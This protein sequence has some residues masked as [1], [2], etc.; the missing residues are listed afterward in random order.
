MLSSPRLLI[1][2]S[3][4]LV[5]AAFFLPWV[6][7]LPGKR[8]RIERPGRADS[9]PLLNPKMRGYLKAFSTGVK[10][11][12]LTVRS[13]A[14]LS[15]YAIPQAANSEASKAAVQLAE[16]FQGK[17][18]KK[19]V[20]RSVGWK[21]YAVYLVPGLHLFLGALLLRFGRLRWAAAI[22]GLIGLVVPPIAYWQI[23]KALAQS[24]GLATIE[25]GLWLSLLAYWVLAAA[26][27]SFTKPPQGLY[28]HM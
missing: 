23:T 22:V 19:A 17:Q 8:A 18:T 11:I 1:R 9:K 10:S 6:Q 28:T 20:L 16:A 12:E 14:R 3:M 25:Y 27:R 13:S 2:A 21:S 15:G 4:L 26:A 24:S 5:V 7:V